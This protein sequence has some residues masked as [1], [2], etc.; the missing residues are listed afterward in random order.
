LTNSFKIKLI[1]IHWIN[2]T[3]D[4][5][6]LCPHGN[7]KVT[8]GN[9]TVVDKNEK[10]D[11]WNLR[12]MAMHLLRTLKENHNE[13]DLVGEH[14]IPCCGHHIDYIKNEQNVYLQGCFTGHNF[15][16]EHKNK[17]VEL[18]TETGKEKILL[19][20]ETYK[21][22]VLKFVDKVSDFYSQSLPRILP[23]DEYDRIA[24]SKFWEEWDKRRSEWNITHHNNG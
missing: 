23:E 24:Y 10:I 22:E 3:D 4:Q 18:I 6:D 13:E 16:V 5:T 17:N 21:N 9:E 19:D 1:D 12:A 2:K 15:W 11:H 14:L 8:V 7:V 20:F